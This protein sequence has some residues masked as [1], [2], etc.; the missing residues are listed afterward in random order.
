MVLSC[1]LLIAA[2]TSTFAITPAKLG[3]PY[4]IVGLLNFMKNVN[5]LIVK[6]MLFTA[7]PI[8]AKRA[9]EIGMINHSVSSD[10]IEKFTCDLIDIIVNN[11]PLAITEM[12]EELRVLSEATSLTPNA[13]AKIQAG[14]TVVY[15]SADYKEG[16]IS[17]LEKRKPVFK[18]L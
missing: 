13:F 11:A 6:E 17:F 10:E 12:K 3:V 5:L 8:T 2:E 4:D 7:H 1:D 16:L 14:R 15:N 18:G 9:Q